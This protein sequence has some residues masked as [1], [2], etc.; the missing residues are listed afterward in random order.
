MAGFDHA[1]APR[2]PAVA[3]ARDRDAADAAR[4]HAAFVEIVPLRDLGHGAAGLAGGQDD[5]ASRWRRGGQMRAAGS[6]PGCAAAT[7]VRN[8][9][10]RKA[11]GEAITVSARL[12]GSSGDGAQFVFSHLVFHHPRYCREFEPAG[13]RD[14]WRS[15]GADPA[16]KRASPS[17]FLALTEFWL[18]RFGFIRVKG[19]AHGAG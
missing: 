19:R 2:R 12:R 1:H 16:G 14:A 4:R 17:L 3:V 6:S 9:S 13:D 10:S 18:T 8:R 15:F 7:A 11:R 5:Q